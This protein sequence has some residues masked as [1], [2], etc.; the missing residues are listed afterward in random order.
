MNGSTLVHCRAELSTSR[1]S[2]CG[3]SVAR[4]SPTCGPWQHRS[5]PPGRRGPLSLHAEGW[6]P[7]EEL[8]RCTESNDGA[9]L[10]I[11][12]QNSAVRIPMQN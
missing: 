5:V 1:G 11:S 4:Y 9:Y 10:S 12:S 2:P 7:Y 8:L 6:R 3:R